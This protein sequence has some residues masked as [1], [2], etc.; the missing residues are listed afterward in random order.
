MRRFLVFWLIVSHIFTL[1]V[2]AQSV[3]VRPGI[4]TS[5]RGVI[6]VSGQTPPKAADGTSY[7]GSTAPSRTPGRRGGDG[8]H[9]AQADNPGQIEVSLRDLRSAAEIEQ[10]NERGAVAG[11]DAVANADVQRFYSETSIDGEVEVQVTVKKSAKGFLNSTLDFIRGA[12]SGG[13][14]KIK[15]SFDQTL[16]LIARGGQGGDAG[17]GGHG[18]QGGR[19]RNGADATRYSEGEDGGPG[20]EGG[21]GGHG[22]KATDA[23]DGG[24]VSVEVSA[25]Q[26]YL[27]I[28][29]DK[30][31]SDVAGARGGY[32][33]AAGRG[34]EGGDGGSGGSSYSWSETETYTDSEGK[35]QTR[36]IIRSKSGGSDGPRGSAGRNGIDGGDGRSSSAGTYKFSVKDEFGRITSY[37][38]RFKIHISHYEMVTPDHDNVFEPGEE[39][40]LKNLTITNASTMPFP[41]GTRLLIAAVHDGLI[42]NLSKPLVL[43][44]G[45]EGN[46]THTFSENLRV[47]P[48]EIREDEIKLNETHVRR[49]RLQLSAQVTVIGRELP[50]ADN[51]IEANETISLRFPV[52]IVWI[53]SL[54]AAIPGEYQR[55]LIRIKNTSSKELGSASEV[56]RAVMA[57]L[58]ANG[59][60]DL[61]EEDLDL[62]FT[63]LQVTEFNEQ[64][65]GTSATDLIR[66][67]AILGRKNSFIS[68]LLALKPGEEKT[69]VAEVGVRRGVKAGQMFEITTRLSQQAHLDNKEPNER[70]AT[71][72]NKLLE[73]NSQDNSRPMQTVALGNFII[74]TGERYQPD[75]NADVLFISHTNITTAHYKEWERLLR[76]L[77]L[78]M[79]IWNIGIEGFL[80][81][82]EFGEKTHG[83][84]RLFES[85]Y[86]KTIVIPTHLFKLNGEIK[87]ALD[88]LDLIQMR[89]A[90]LEGKVNFLFV[91]P[92]GETLSRLNQSLTPLDE[93]PADP[94]Y[95]GSVIDGQSGSSSVDYRMAWRRA[96]LGSFVLAINSQ[97]DSSAESGLSAADSAGS[98]ALVRRAE[99]LSKQLREWR[100]KNG[101]PVAQSL[102]YNFP[103]S[104]VDEF[105]LSKWVWFHGK[106]K[107]ELLETAKEF[108]Q[109]VADG[110]RSRQPLATFFATHEFSPRIVRNLLFGALKKVDFGAILIR[111]ALSPYDGQYTFL[112]RDTLSG[113]QSVDDLQKRGEMLAADAAQVETRTT[114]LAL[115]MSLPTETLER[116]MKWYQIGATGIEESSNEADA[117]G[118]EGLLAGNPTW[119]EKEKLEIFEELLLALTDKVL[120]EQIKLGARAQF[121]RS[122]AEWEAFVPALMKFTSMR[123][124]LAFADKEMRSRT[125]DLVASLMAVF[126]SHPSWWDRLSGANIHWIERS[127]RR[128]LEQFVIANIV[129]FDGQEKR[130]VL[131]DLA[132]RFNQ[133]KKAIWKEGK[134]KSRYNQ[135]ARA[136]RINAA[137]NRVD[138][139]IIGKLNSS[140]GEIVNSR[141]I[142]QGA[143]AELHPESF[144]S[145]AQR[146]QSQIVESNHR[147]RRRNEGIRKAFVCERIF[148][149][150]RQ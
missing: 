124:P 109:Y 77:D 143:S 65:I 102:D 42:L 85:F 127:C 122:R 104:S 9:G 40:E 106:S 47:Y 28:M 84:D 21:A 133:H 17:D 33:G 72:E 6:D 91:G 15:V 52:E 138:L 7:S 99:K 142:Q 2:V 69:M 48:R 79:N 107:G 60:G 53:K 8:G 12:W 16:R 137:T 136:N 111:K 116:M 22:G 23:T 46:S 108:G 101:L 59:Q 25:N 68:D 4:E 150:S 35:T 119:T 112:K 88:Y 64:T 3:R 146:R 31:S 76:R 129:N 95:A 58:N 26:T 145:E 135:S 131:R 71:E 80:N 120:T 94:R 32:G 66:N 51:T 93:R 141:R 45:L 114:R 37:D 36:T 24:K 147:A 57:Q 144:V 38:E 126:H 115:L 14:Q 86:G 134:K 29:I 113:S 50:E 96:E 74:T 105:G 5:K 67:A 90:T 128:M 89:M 140:E 125:L 1:D 98:R 27:L 103:S 39:I 18:Q 54:E 73:Q 83:L 63:N 43:T 55:V 123:M 81:L 148:D 132:D 75:E 44:Q 61:T 56:K 87:S 117:Y 130:V 97:R 82:L 100:H 92:S 41:K 70:G 10:A 49:H 19:G 118:L 149:L 110:V 13:T 34:G 121:F 62:Q 30:Q 11:G 78:K 20:S 139:G